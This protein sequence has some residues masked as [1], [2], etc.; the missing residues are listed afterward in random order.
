M[1]AS[2]KFLSHPLLGLC[3]AG[4]LATA[5]ATTPETPA[6]EPSGAT[7]SA[8]AGPSE[9]DRQ[10]ILAM[11]GNYKVKFDFTETV[12][13]KEGYELKEKK[14]SG[15]NEVVLVLEDRPGFISLQH[16]LVVGGP[17]QKFPVKH[18]RQDWIYEPAYIYDFA[19]FNSWRKRALS[20]EERKGKWAQIVYQVDDSPR[21]AAVA[22]WTYDNGIPSWSSPFNM[23]PLPRRDM[24][25][26]D[27]YHGIW[28]VNRHAITPGGWV[29]EQDNTKVILT[30]PA[31]EALVRETGINTYDKFDDFPVDVATSYWEATRDYWAGVR[32]IWTSLEET[33]DEIGLTLQGEPIDLYTPLLEY[34]EDVEEGTLSVA[35]AIEEAEETIASFT[36]TDIE[37]SIAQAIA[38][39]TAL[40]PDGSSSG[41]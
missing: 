5:C 33:S 31:P 1:P 35:E 34:A 29:H 28:A 3:A 7:A 25:T 15:G 17:D 9:Q 41:E 23:R 8:P 2:L 10:S 30:G 21:Y 13:L 20:A 27:D 37:P 19:G 18:W 36:V 38:E 12:V 6:T 39:A 14:I 26:R 22:E 4:L 11:A 40:I 24:T 16:I 32:A